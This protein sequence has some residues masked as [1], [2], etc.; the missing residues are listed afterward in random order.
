MSKAKGI[1]AR[2]WFYS[3]GFHD[4]RHEPE[5][6]G[7][8]ADAFLKLAGKSSEGDA[9]ADECPE[10]GADLNEIRAKGQS[11]FHGDK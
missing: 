7:A 9:S 5:A 2:G 6:D 8:I 1:S 3:R 10:C 4:I 11:H